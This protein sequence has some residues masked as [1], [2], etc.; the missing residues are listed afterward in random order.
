KLK[1]WDFAAAG[2][3]LSEVGGY[4]DAVDNSSLSLTG[5]PM[6]FMACSARELFNQVVQKYFNC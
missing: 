6:A 3:I 1:A 4:Y 2:I 5:K